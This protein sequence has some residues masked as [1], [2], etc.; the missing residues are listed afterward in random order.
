MKLSNC[1]W[2]RGES[3]FRRNKK[4][5]F[6]D[7]IEAA[8]SL[9]AHKDVVEYANCACLEELKIVSARSKEKREKCGRTWTKSDVQSGFTIHKG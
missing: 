4:A 3:E 9:C 2:G 7:Q 8:L 1:F 6:S 5:N